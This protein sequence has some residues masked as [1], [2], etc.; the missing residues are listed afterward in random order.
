MNEYV[1]KYRKVVNELINKSFPSL[2][3]KKFKIFE[4]GIIRIYGIYLFGNFIGMNKKC[5]DFSEDEIKGI[6]GHELC[7]AEYSNKIGFLKSCLIFIRYWLFLKL[8][9]KEEIKTDKQTIKKGY[10]K[11]LFELARKIELDLDRKDVRYG[12]S[13]E[14]IKTYAKKTGK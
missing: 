1:E 12:L 7:H 11:E 4:F 6:L 3:E 5:R 8:R 9:I 13:S 2:R 14:Q 10:A